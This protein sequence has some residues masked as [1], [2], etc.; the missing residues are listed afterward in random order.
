MWS[1]C[2]GWGEVEDR[3]AGAL[4]EEEGQLG[5]DGEGWGHT[6]NT[7]EGLYLGFD[8]GFGSGGVLH[9]LGVIH[10]GRG[11]EHT[12]QTLVN[13]NTWMSINRR[14]LAHVSN[15][16]P[17]H[18]SSPCEPMCVRS[19]SLRLSPMFISLIS[20]LLWYV[21]TRSSLPLSSSVPQ[22]LVCIRSAML[23]HIQG[24]GPFRFR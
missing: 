3:Y 11:G 4:G 6:G 16:S 22:R 19:N 8:V 21:H 10:G 17:G 12:T 1:A 5:C 7:I 13:K 2:G 15:T 9:L 14:E 20:H 18:V 24:L 23:R